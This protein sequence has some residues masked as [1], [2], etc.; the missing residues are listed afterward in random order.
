MEW[1]E[2]FK[3]LFSRWYLYFIAIIVTLYNAENLNLNI[4]TNLTG[5]LIFFISE[6]I[7]IGLIISL[8][9]TISHARLRK[10]KII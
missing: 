3:W 4:Y 8:I 10:P 1:K 7:V 5:T 6:I 9:Y 2:Y